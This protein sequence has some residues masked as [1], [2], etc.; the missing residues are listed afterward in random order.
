M[1]IDKENHNCPLLRNCKNVDRNGRENS[2]NGELGAQ[3]PNN[4]VPLGVSNNPRESSL[5]FFTQTKDD[6]SMV[7]QFFTV[8]DSPDVSQV[9]PSNPSPTSEQ[10]RLTR[11]A[12][13]EGHMELCEALE[14]AG[15]N[16]AEHFRK[17]FNC[18]QK[19]IPSTPN[20]PNLATKLLN[21]PDIDDIDC[22]DL[23]FPYNI[24]TKLHQTPG[25]SKRRSSIILTPLSEAPRA[26][27]T[28]K[29]SY[30]PSKKIPYLLPPPPKC[31]NRPP[32]PPQIA[33][34][35]YFN[36]PRSCTV[37]GTEN[38]VIP[39]EEKIKILKGVVAFVDIYHYGSNVSHSIAV[40]LES[41][42]ATV[43]KTFAKRVTHLVFS[44]GKKRH[45]WQAITTK[46]PIVSVL[47][48]EACKLARL[49]VDPMYYRPK[50]LEEE[51]DSIPCHYFFPRIRRS[52]WRKDL[53]KEKKK[54]ELMAKRAMSSTGAKRKKVQTD[55][56]LTNK[57]CH[58]RLHFPG[59][60]E[61]AQPNESELPLV[62]DDAQKLGKRRTR[63]SAPAGLLP[64]IK[65]ESASQ[66]KRRKLF[67][68]KDSV[69]TVVSSEEE[70][71][72]LNDSCKTVMSKFSRDKNTTAKKN[73]NAL[74]EEQLTDCSSFLEFLTP[75][76]D[77]KTPK[78]KKGI[79]FTC[80][81]KSMMTELTTMVNSLGGFIVERKVS[82]TTTHVVTC[83]ERRTMNLLKGIL[84]GC[85]VVDVQWVRQCSEAGKWL[86]EEPYEIK[87]MS[88]ASVCA[89]LERQAFGGANYSMDLLS[90]CGTF[91]VTRSTDANYKDIEELIKLAKGVIVRRSKDA[92]IIIGSRRCRTRGKEG[93]I[94]LFEK[95]VAECIQA[96]A[97]VAFDNFIL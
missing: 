17:A 48:I 18:H 74:L 20:Q 56:T 63:Q 85:W 25:Q 88:S 41:M 62:D 14:N 68:R 37:E 9:V 66:T 94:R 22:N 3:P 53:D 78:Q 60:N 43:M 82:S 59:D 7:K 77:S 46:T 42:G 5:E 61:V 15:M 6:D 33:A 47:W 93:S 26:F 91:F 54:R 75:K 35:R 44:H 51:Y 13:F 71:V 52:D 96:N 73:L 4:K 86:S 81:L 38:L 8:E 58:K 24:L 36:T 12:L 29:N 11:R 34:P 92:D 23:P 87:H 55:K 89:R 67:S 30:E 49:P 64:L 27:S 57:N 65:N 28:P 90:K 19:N 10:R 76:C 72:Q 80:C 70:S 79:V 39:P 97:V 83:G 40:E 31:P 84:R 2:Y 32:S 21:T 50:H 1:N 45:Y 69:V 95:W 16:P